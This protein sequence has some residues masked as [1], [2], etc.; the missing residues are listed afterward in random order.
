VAEQTED[1]GVQLQDL[2]HSVANVRSL[3]EKYH[4]ISVE[5]INKIVDSGHDFINKFTSLIEEVR[6]EVG[7]LEELSNLAA[8]GLETFESFNTTTQQRL[9]Q[10]RERVESEH[11]KECLPTGQTP[12]KRK[13]TFPTTLP[14]TGTAEDVLARARG[15]ARPVLGEKEVNSPQKQTP[16]SSSILADPKSGGA[17]IGAAFYPTIANKKMFR[18]IAGSGSAGEHGGVDE[19]EPSSSSGEPFPGGGDDVRG[20]RRKKRKSTEADSGSGISTITTR[21]RL[22]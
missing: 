10:L 4:E 5:S 14:S 17:G 9:S 22:R 11:L 18:D 19:N 7:S 2:D 3:N 21:R 12:R 1:V 6:G 8:E 16:E 20:V 13:Y 15:I